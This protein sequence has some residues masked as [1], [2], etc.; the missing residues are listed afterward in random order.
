MMQMAVTVPV[1]VE[2]SF[3]KD[4]QL[5]KTHTGSQNIEE[6]F[7]RFNDM[8]GPLLFMGASIFRFQDYDMMNP[9]IS[10]WKNFSI[11]LFIKLFLLIAFCVPLFVLIVINLIRIF[12]LWIWIS[13]APLAAIAWTFDDK[14]TP[15]FIKDTGDKLGFGKI[16]DVLKLIFQPVAMIGSLALVMI[17]SIGMYYVLGGDPG[18]QDANKNFNKTIEQVQLESKG[19]LSTLKDL[20]SGTEISVEGDLFKEAGNF[21]GGMIGYLIITGFT[22]V[23]LWSLIKISASFS[24][25]TKT[26]AENI[27]KWSE[28]LVTNTDIIPIG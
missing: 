8:S 16:S 3:K 24:K 5:F 4:Q 10:S 18:D 17:M 14:S 21:V 28:K 25:F 15:K 11:G 7:G 19:E 22:V 6:M 27:F 12:R 1:K 20:T 26:T 23:L 2:V 13:F 9:D